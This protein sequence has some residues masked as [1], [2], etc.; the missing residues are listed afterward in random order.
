MVEG[1]DRIKLGMGR[2]SRHTLSCPGRYGAA[3]MGAVAVVIQRRE[4][5][6]D[7]I[8]AAGD[9]IPQIRMG[10]VHAGIDDANP[11]F[12]A[13]CSFPGKG[14]LDVADAPGDKGFAPG[15]AGLAAD[16]TGG[17]PGGLILYDRQRFIPLHS[18][19]LGVVKE[20]LR[21]LQLEKNGINEGKGFNL[22][23]GAAAGFPEPP[24][25]FTAIGR[26]PESDE[27]ACR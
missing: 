18:L 10:E 14:G 21:R 5:A 22:M 15:E 12:L 13:R 4:V 3:D 26:G 1:L 23:G 20:S 27:I 24:D 2:H 7:Q 25:N 16:F 11:D 8:N 9:G 17:Q 6:V 19:H